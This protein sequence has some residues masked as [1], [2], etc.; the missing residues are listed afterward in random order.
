MN[1]SYI[2]LLS[3]YWNRLNASEAQKKLGY[4]S[5]EMPEKQAALIAAE[6]KLKSLMYLTD[7]N[8]AVETVDI[9]RAKREI[10]ILNSVY[11]MLRKE[12][13]QAR[14]EEAKEISPF[15]D[16]EYATVPK[17]PESRRTGLN[18]VMGLI[19]GLLG[20]SFTAFFIESSSKRKKS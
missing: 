11:A 8:G 20:G 1:D 7:E 2:G 17:A 9:L 16:V 19:I 14:L 13:E 3:D 6:D 5:K 18:A 4:I 15:S 10:E 12:Y